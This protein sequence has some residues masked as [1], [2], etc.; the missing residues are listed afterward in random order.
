MEDKIMLIGDKTMLIN[1]KVK[2]M[3]SRINYLIRSAERYFNKFG[4]DKTYD[5]RLARIEASIDM[6]AILTEKEYSY[7]EN[8]LYEV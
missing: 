5:V 1:D 8:G 6:L 2:K 7:D 4:W 3:E